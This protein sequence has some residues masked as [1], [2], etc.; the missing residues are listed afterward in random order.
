VW[1]DSS[2]KRIVLRS[3]SERASVTADS[4][5]NS[6]VSRVRR[7]EGRSQISLRSKKWQ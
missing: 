5:A 4:V 3:P 7:S 2:S 1:L 6:L